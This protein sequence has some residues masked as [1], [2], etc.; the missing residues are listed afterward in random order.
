VKSYYASIDYS[1]ATQLAPKK[2]AGAETRRSVSQAQQQS[3]LGREA[4][5]GNALKDLTDRSSF[6]T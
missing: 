2:L 4:G 5:S 1:D 3:E 6:F